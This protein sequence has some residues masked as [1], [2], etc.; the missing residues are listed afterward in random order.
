MSV[1]GVYYLCVNAGTLELE[2]ITKL[3][4]NGIEFK[5]IHLKMHAT[6]MHVLNASEEK[7]QY[8]NLQGKGE[9]YHITFSGIWTCI[10]IQSD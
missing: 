6:T 3:L 4:S 8:Q 2:D 9:Q 1:L 7:Y 10:S 5:Y